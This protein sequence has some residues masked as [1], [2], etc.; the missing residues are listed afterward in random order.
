MIKAQCCQ[1]NY[2]TLYTFNEDVCATNHYASIL[3]DM[4]YLK[5]LRRDGSAL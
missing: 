5:V 4:F 1:R 3:S 2:G